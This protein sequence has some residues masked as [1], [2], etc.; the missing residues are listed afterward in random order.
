MFVLV[1]TLFV[2]LTWMWFPVT[3]SLHCVNGAHS[4]F[5]L[6]TI[7]CLEMRDKNERWVA[8][9]LAEELDTNTP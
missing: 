4:N 2:R 6:S 9:N 7:F 8:S 3:V 5:A 1:G